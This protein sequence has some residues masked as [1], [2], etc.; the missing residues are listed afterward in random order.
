MPG[1]L[2]PILPLILLTF[3]GDNPKLTGDA[4]AEVSIGTPAS[5]S[6]ETVRQV[7]RLPYGA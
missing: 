3:Q 1:S 5:V 7:G 6:V 4:S 2:P